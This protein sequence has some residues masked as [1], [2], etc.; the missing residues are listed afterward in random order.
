MRADA[1]RETGR[2]DRARHDRTKG[3][4]AARKKVRLVAA[5]PDDAGSA[6]RHGNVE[7]PQHTAEA[8]DDGSRRYFRRSRRSADEASV[9]AREHGAGGADARDGRNGQK[10]REKEQ[11][12]ARRRRRKPVA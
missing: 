7:I 2:I 1:E 9:T 11:R 8:N 12:W 10:S 3:F 6:R 4:A 5:T